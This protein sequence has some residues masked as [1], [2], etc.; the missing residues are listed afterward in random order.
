MRKVILTIFSTLLFSSVLY[1]QERITIGELDNQVNIHNIYGKVI[2]RKD[3]TSLPGVNIY[4]PSLQKGVSTDIDGNFVLK[5]RKGAYDLSIT[6]I[7]YEE[8]IIK[9]NLVGD[10]NLLIRLDESSTQLEEIIVTGKDADANVT[11]TDIGKTNL[12]VE[13][14]KDLPPFMGEVDILKSITLLPGVSTVGEA[15]SGFNV[16]GGGSDQNL[17]LLGGATIYNP[18]HLFGLYTAFNSE[19]VDDVT[20]YKGGIPAKFGGRSASIVD[21]KY[22]DGDMNAWNGQVSLGTVSSKLAVNGPIIND[23]L[24][25]SLGG[26]VSYVNYLLNMVND[27]SLANS[28]AFF[29]DGNAILTYRLNDK[30]KLSYS[31]YQSGD[32]FKLTSDTAY[33]WQNRGHVLKW[34]HAFNDNAAINVSAVRSKYDFEI[35]NDGN[36]SSFDITS[37]IIDDALNIDYE[38]SPNEQNTFSMGVQGKLYRVNPGDLQPGD[39]TSPI[40]PKNIEDEKALE[41]AAYFQH[42]IELGERFA[43]SYGLRYNLYNYLGPKTVST[44]ADYVPLSNESRLS[45]TSYGDNENIQQYSGFEPRASFR[46]TLNPTSSIKLG[47]NRMYQYIQVVSNT[48]TIAPTDIWKLSD[49]FIKPQIVDQYSIGFFKNFAE[50]AWETSVEGYFKQMDNILEYKDG[51]SLIL[52]ENLETELLNGQ[53]YAYGVELFV[54]KK[55]GKFNGW[56]SYTYSRS[57]R[58]V[59]GAYPITRVNNGD[60]YPSNFDKPHDF[61]FVSNYRINQITSFSAIFTYSSGRPITVPSAKFNFNGSELAYFDNRNQDRAP[62][63]HRLDLSLTFSIPSKKKLLQGDWV[64]AIYNVYGRKNAYSVFFKDVDGSPPQAFRLAVLGVPFPSLSY[65]VTF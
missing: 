39:P 32:E 54:K 15:S 29:F 12:S 22:K 58:L 21:I 57:L 34:T 26:R 65:A 13:R 61:T 4:V 44:Y 14:I 20:L 24:S 18:T 48:T 40:N 38:W 30:N 17:I 10:G 49:T 37:G 35:R 56:F 6:Y 42:D 63:Y 53:G 7:G 50:N 55:I 23:R 2:S 33:V 16:R 11:S 31:F 60:W 47:Y 51:A 3:R 46:W 52:N 27:P 1:S 43:I 62:D 41:T 36:I 45:E 25:L 19:L 5:L 28:E 64:L 59:D 9:I 8:R